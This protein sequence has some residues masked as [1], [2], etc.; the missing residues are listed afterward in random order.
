[1]GSQVTLFS[2]DQC[3]YWKSHH[4][5]M[6]FS[7]CLIILNKGNHSSSHIMPASISWHHHV[8]TG[9]HITLTWCPLIKFMWCDYWKSHHSHLT[10]SQCIIITK[11]DNQHVFNFYSS[12][13]MSASISWHQHVTTGSHITIT[14]S[15]FIVERSAGW[16]SWTSYTIRVLDL[17][18]LWCLKVLCIMIV[19]AALL[20]VQR[21]M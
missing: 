1:M 21:A 10:F 2:H 4:S 14:W 8:T 5:H 19:P 17:F 7:H 13:Q 12:S 11:K 16:R 3:D 20:F 18:G 6:I 15:V 9:S